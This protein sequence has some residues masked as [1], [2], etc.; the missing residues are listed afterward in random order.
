MIASRTAHGDVKGHALFAVVVSRQ[1]ALQHFL[2]FVDAHLG[3]KPERAHVHAEDGNVFR[4]VTGDG[5]ERAVAAERHQQIGVLTE[6][7]LGHAFAAIVK[8][9]GGGVIEADAE[10]ARA[11]IGGHV[12]SESQRFLGGDLRRDTD[13]LHATEFT[14]TFHAYNFRS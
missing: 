13:R 4:R 7:A 9:V 1:H 11:K 3:E 8:L 12:C 5:E 10:I 6:L 14:R 2:E